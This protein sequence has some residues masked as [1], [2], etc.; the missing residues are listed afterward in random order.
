MGYDLKPRNKKA[1]K[2]SIN[3]FSWSWM[4]EA[5]VGLPVGYGPGL[6]HGQFVCY[7]RPDGLC[8]ESNDGARVT[9]AE[10]KEMAKIARYVADYQDILYDQ[11]AKES[12]KIRERM[13]DNVHG[14]YNCPVRKD[15][16]K[17]ARDFADWAEK[18]G[19][20]RVY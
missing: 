13:Q 10:A 6:K 14:I 17:N 18:S 2:F 12:D 1:N 4:L 11:Y 8:I 5:G 15:F 3:A 20:F 9:A 16:V 7:V 19:G